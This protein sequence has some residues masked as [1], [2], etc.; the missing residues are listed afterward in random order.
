MWWPL[1][2]LTFH[3]AEVLQE[4]ILIGESE[5]SVVY[6]R[7]IQDSRTRPQ[8]LGGANPLG[9]G[10]HLCGFKDEDLARWEVYIRRRAGCG[11][12]V[13]KGEPILKA[14]AAK[15]DRFRNPGRYFKFLSRPIYSGGELLRL[16]GATIVNFWRCR[17][18]VLRTM[19]CFAV[20]SLQRSAEPAIEIRSA[21]WKPF[22]PPKLGSQMTPGFLTSSATFWRAS[23]NFIG[24]PDLS[25]FCTFPNLPEVQKD[26]ITA[27]LSQ[28]IRKSAEMR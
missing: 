8:L 26:A 1:E 12:M 23:G 14:K 28:T 24:T 27:D 5:T 16:G 2:H 7:R 15:R 19:A 11:W 22:I 17:T 3:R 21:S 25:A 18:V 9:N 13:V 10:V 6:H 20:A 4:R